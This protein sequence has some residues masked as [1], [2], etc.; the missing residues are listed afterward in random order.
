MSE[1]NNQGRELAWDDVITKDSEFILLP[2][3]DYDFVVENF[4]RARHNGSEKLPACYK[5]IIKITIWYEGQKVTIDHNLFLHSSTESMLSAFF[6]SIGQ[7]KKGESLK[8]NWN[9]VPGASGKCKIGHQEYNGNKYNQIKKF[10]PAEEKKGFVPG[11][12]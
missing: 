10:Y 1:F 12:F 7:K 8:M 2:E 11:N 4:E 3:G 9:A 6:S 5:A